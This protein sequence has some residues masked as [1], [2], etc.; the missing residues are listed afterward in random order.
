MAEA[1]LPGWHIRDRPP[2]SSQPSG[3]RGS[4]LAAIALALLLLPIP[5]AA[6]DPR[7]P[8]NR[9]PSGSAG[10]CPWRINAYLQQDLDQYWQRQQALHRNV[11]ITGGSSDLV[12]LVMG[13]IDRRV[14]TGKVEGR[15]RELSD[16]ALGH[17][18]C[19]PVWK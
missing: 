17:Y 11:P 15:R 14:L 4:R 1:V 10:S 5:A 3:P 16:W 6:A 7:T 12:S 8:S 9:A 19:R 2:R 13:W 18:G